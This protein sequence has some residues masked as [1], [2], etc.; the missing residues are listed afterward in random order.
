[1]IRIPVPA[2]LSKRTV[3]TTVAAAI[4]AGTSAMSATPASAYVPRPA[5]SSVL[6]CTAT[7][8]EICVGL[9][10]LGT[11]VFSMQAQVHVSQHSNV[12]YAFGTPFSTVDAFG[13]SGG[14]GWV[15]P[16]ATI[17]LNQDYSLGARFCALAIVNTIVSTQ[18]C[19]T[20]P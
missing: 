5:A 8:P 2:V 4:L 6:T 12:T 9:N 20:L 10:Y 15:Q 11:H 3:G 14:P 16:A 7:D 17:Q 19:V 18:A 1:M 13:Y